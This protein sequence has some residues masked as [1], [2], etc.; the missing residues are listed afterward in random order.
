MGTLPV[1]RTENCVAGAP[2]SHNLINEI[3]DNIIA[4]NR[5]SFTRTFWPKLINSAAWSEG[6]ISIAAGAPGASTGTGIGGEPR[7]YYSTASGGARFAIPFEDGDRITG[8]SIEMR[9]DGVHGS[10]LEIDWHPNMANT[11]TG[12][13][14]P[15]GSWNVATHA[16]G[17][18]VNNAGAFTPTVLGAGNMLYVWIS[19]SG[20][21]L[22][23]GPVVATFDRLA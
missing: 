10:L 4:N 1:F 7:G 14:T 12:A 20:A 22:A 19:A 3:Q 23:F 11:I 8:L 2:V 9:G 17:F 15:I 21:G 18:V 5:A 6:S 16:S 13:G